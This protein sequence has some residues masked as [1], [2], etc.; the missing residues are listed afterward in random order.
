MPYLGK[1][2]EIGCLCQYLLLIL[3]LY[4]KL[5]IPAE[6]DPGRWGV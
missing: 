4:S 2:M 3:F 5:R 6:A 1:E